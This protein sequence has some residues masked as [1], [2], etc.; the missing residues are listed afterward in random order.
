MFEL[1]IEERR[2]VDFIARLTIHNSSVPRNKRM[3]GH[4]KAKNGGRTSAKVDEANIKHLHE[5]LPWR[6]STTLTSWYPN[7]T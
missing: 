4:M 5:L 3:L 1:L 7:H 6:R 2:R